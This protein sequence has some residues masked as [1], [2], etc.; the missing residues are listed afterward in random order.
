LSRAK[1]A[2]RHSHEVYESRFAIFVTVGRIIALDYG[3]KRTG[4]AVTDELRITANGLD[5]I[6]TPKLWDF[7]VKY[8]QDE[9]VDLLV[10]GEP[11]RMNDEPSDVEK[12]IQPFINR[13]RKNFPNIEV[14]R[15]DERFTSKL[16][17]DALIRGGAKQ[18]S[19]RNKALIDK[20]SATIILQSYLQENE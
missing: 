9:P 14:V 11:K 4:V 12:S 2:I 3:N 15:Q 18:K 20:V 7:L 17:M 1:V 13:F 8:I 16:A 19:R 6:E 10:V 5:T